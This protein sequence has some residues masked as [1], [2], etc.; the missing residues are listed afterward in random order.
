MVRGT[1]VKVVLNGAVI[2]DVDTD[3]VLDPGLREKHPGLER[4]SGHVGFLGHNEPVEFRNIRIKELP[5]RQ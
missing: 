5:A 4:R 1:R 3:G 2:L